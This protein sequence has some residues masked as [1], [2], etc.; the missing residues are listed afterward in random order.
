MQFAHTRR[1]KNHNRLLKL[2]RERFRWE[3]LGWE[4]VGK[5]FFYSVN[6]QAQGREAGLPAQASFWSGMLGFGW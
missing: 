3:K 2:K 4:I 5:G 6:I 1:S